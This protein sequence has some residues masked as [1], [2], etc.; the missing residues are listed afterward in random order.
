MSAKPGALMTLM[1]VDPPAIIRF[2]VD[3]QDPESMKKIITLENP[4][5]EI[6]AFKLKTTAPDAFVL[7]PNTGTLKP[8][9]KAQVQVIL[10]LKSIDKAQGARFQIQA[11]KSDGGAETR[12]KEQLQVWWKEQT[13]VQDAI[14]SVLC[15][16]VG[17]TGGRAAP[18][19]PNR[20]GA[21][22]P[23]PEVSTEQLEK[24]HAAL[25]R[26]VKALQE[27][28]LRLKTVVE[29]MSASKQQAL[30]VAGAVF[31]LS[32]LARRRANYSG[33]FALLLVMLRDGAFAATAAL[34]FSLGQQRK[35]RA[36]AA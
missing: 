23:V 31:V 28:V 30:I 5:S 14:L 13:K 12:T 26:E 25:E 8:G 19:S 21:L 32:R 1:K 36:V 7:R 16:V 4:G 20:S 2:K 34:A 29:H 24:Y 10:Q 11:A 22:G 3:K 35:L 17:G 18:A 6:A 27:H 9:E 15:E 33:L